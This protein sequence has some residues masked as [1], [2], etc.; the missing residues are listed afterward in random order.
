MGIYT[1]K[2]NTGEWVYA[3]LIG[4]NKVMNIDEVKT[5]SLDYDNL[6]FKNIKVGCRRDD[7][8]VQ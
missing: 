5:K 6:K 2:T 4:T 7:Y 1:W 3:I 8:L